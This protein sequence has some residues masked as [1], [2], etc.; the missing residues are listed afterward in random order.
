MLLWHLYFDAVKVRVAN[1]RQVYYSL[2]T[3][4]A[5]VAKRIKRQIEGEEA[6]GVPLCTRGAR[7]LLHNCQRKT[8]HT[9]EVS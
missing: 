2:R 9:R 1:G 4:D 6:K 3:N 8:S 5:R 7:T